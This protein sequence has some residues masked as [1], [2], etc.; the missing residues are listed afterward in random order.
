MSAEN[1]DPVV[2][3]FIPGKLGSELGQKEPHGYEIHHTQ[4]INSGTLTES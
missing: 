4:A 1:P 3:V 2:S